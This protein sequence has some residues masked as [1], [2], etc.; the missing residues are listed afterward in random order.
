M[1]LFL[2]NGLTGYARLPIKEIRH[3]D[4][5]DVQTI[6]QR[7]G[8][9]R[10][11]TQKSPYKMQPYGC[12]NNAQNGGVCIRHGAKVKSIRIRTK[13]SRDGCIHK[14][15]RVHETWCN[16]INLQSQSL[17]CWEVCALPR[18]MVGREF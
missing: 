9:I 8:E 16:E 1:V 17:P 10:G 3:A 13:C 12:I 5:R 7:R 11:S 4:M 15:R 6:R 18:H 14:R 2:S